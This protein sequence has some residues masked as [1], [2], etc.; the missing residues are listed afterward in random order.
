[1]PF[2]DSTRHEPAL[3]RLWEPKI[4]IEDSTGGVLRENFYVAGKHLDACED[5]ALD[6]SVDLFPDDT[7]SFLEDYERVYELSEIG[8]D[9]VRQNRIVTAHRARGGLTAEYFK[10]LGDTLGDGTYTVE[11][12][13][14]TGNIPFIVA[15]FSP[16]SSPQGPATVL[17]G[18]VYGAA[19]STT[20]WLIRVD[21]SGSSGPELDLEST[22]NRLKAAHTDMTYIY[23]L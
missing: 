11:L 20:P 12:S 21:V 10:G 16:I 4:L 9:E 13:D 18:I 2:A 17:P 19:G 15:E 22:F 7:T 5:S 6:L 14:G 8:S 3:N 23:T 1:M